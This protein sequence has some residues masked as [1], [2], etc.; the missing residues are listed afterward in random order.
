VVQCVAGTPSVASVTSGID[1]LVDLGRS[2]VGAGLRRPGLGHVAII[3]GICVDRSRLP[4]AAL[5]YLPLCI[6]I[7]VTPPPPPLS[8]P[9]AMMELGATVCRPA[10]PDCGACPLAGVCGARAAWAAYLEGG[11]DPEAPGA[12][13]VT[14]YP[15]KVSQVELCSAVLRS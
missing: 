5:A 2:Q 12:P 11:G 14:Q 8:C 10:N 15:G 7:H 4:A 9:P 6:P 1:T 3:L 13:R